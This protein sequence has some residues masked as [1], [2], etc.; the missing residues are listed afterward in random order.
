MRDLHRPLLL[1]SLA[2]LLTVPFLH[3]HHYIPI[4]TFFQEWWAALFSL[5]ALSWLLRP[6]AGP[7]IEFPEIGFLPLGLLALA[8]LQLVFLDHAIVGRSLM[9]TLY[10]V[11]A[12]LMVVLG[13]R[14]ARDLGLAALV[15]VLATAVLV[16][17]LLEALS[18]V[19]QAAGLARLPWV[20][21]GPAGGLRG[22]LGQ[23][24]NFAD[25]LWL[26]VASCLYLA[27]S[28]KLRPPL[29]GACL[30]LLVPISLLSGSRSVW[31]Y[32]TG[33]VLLAFLAP[34]ADAAVTRRLR[35]GSVLALLLALVSELA[36]RS[37]LL[38]LPP[39]MASSGARL[40][41]SGPY[42][43][44]R[45][46]LWG[47]AWSGFLDA[48]WLGNGFGQFTRLFH[49]RVLDLMPR[50]LP[51]LPEHAHNLL[52]QLLAELG[53]GAG[54][55]TA[56]LGLRWAHSLWRRQR[57]GAVW[58]VMA[59]AG[60]AGIHSALEYPLWYGFFLAPAAL[61]AGAASGTARAIDP[62]RRLAFSLTA[63]FVLGFTVLLTLRSDYTRLEEVFNGRRA[64]A[65][66]LPAL[67]SQILLRPYVDLATAN[68]MDEG[69]DQ[70]P[71]K[72]AVCA[73]AQ[74]FSASKEI[75]FKCAHLLA[76]AGDQEGARLALRKAVA[77]YPDHAARVLAQWKQR[78]AKEPVIALLVARFPSIVGGVPTATS[79]ELPPAGPIPR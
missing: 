68:L 25:Y 67:E 65:D 78:A 62:G 29:V 7:R 26:G 21:V 2:L 69:A 64:A 22:N 63:V 77:A 73:R 10:M 40:A 46:L 43:P 15:D 57:D 8:L 9:F 55:L 59:V 76:L 12:A 52:L 56:V 32:G 45:W 60:V 58:W 70:L 13:R 41:G 24:N 79:G 16:G 5:L 30:G 66:A 48:P 17:A 34:P 6:A 74:R 1:G 38:P 47:T 4:P 72:L 51:G 61:I 37:S 19:I 71:E 50:R 31:F 14:L 54:L 11:W 3:A 23:P 42:D 49:E 44:L 27:A 33:L 20:F 36:L 39:G 35:R 28:G 75:V 18:G 53:I